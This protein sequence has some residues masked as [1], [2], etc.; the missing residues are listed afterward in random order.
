MT[1]DAQEHIAE[2]QRLLELSEATY[3]PATATCLA[4]QATAHAAIAT[5]LN[6]APVVI[7]VSGPVIPR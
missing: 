5:A 6:T 4:T 1:M 3:S 7:E 2:A